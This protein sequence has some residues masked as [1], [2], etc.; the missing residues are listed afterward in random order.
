MD[1]NWSLSLATVIFI[2][3]LDLFRQ[4][5]WAFAARLRR[6]VKRSCYS[7]FSPVRWPER[8]CPGRSVFDFVSDR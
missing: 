1:T 3:A 2:S 8:G 4:R 7:N 6:R 5:R